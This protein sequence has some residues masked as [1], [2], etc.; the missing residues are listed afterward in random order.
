MNKYSNLFSHSQAK[1]HSAGRQK[2]LSFFLWVRDC[3]VKRFQKHGG[4]ALCTAASVVPLTAHAANF[5]VNTLSDNDADGDTL[6]EA[7]IAANGNGEA[8]TISFAPGL[9]GT[10][11]LTQGQMGITTDLVINGPEERIT[12]SGN[13]FSQIF[14]VGFSSVSLS[15]LIL[16]EGNSQEDLG[17]AIEV[18]EAQLTLTNCEISNSFCLGDGGGIGCGAGGELTLI[19]SV[20]SNNEARGSGGGISAIDFELMLTNCEVSDNTAMEEGGGVFS[21][22]FDDVVVGLTLSNCMITDN[23]A[24]GN[25]QTSGGGVHAESLGELAISN[26]VIA[27]NTAISTAGSV[28]N[29]GG[30]FCGRTLNMTV[31]N[32]EFSNNESSFFG[33]G[34]STE[35]CNDISVNNTTISENRSSIGVGMG[36]YSDRF[37]TLTNCTI[38]GNDSSGATGAGGGLYSSGADNVNVNNCSITANTAEDGGGLFI[39][40]FSQIPSSL[41]IANSICAFND[42]TSGNRDLLLSGANLSLDGPNLFSDSSS[43]GN[44]NA[45]TDLLGQ[46]IEADPANVF[47]TTSVINGITTGTLADNG[48]PV[49]TI[50]LLSGGSAHNAGL[51][52]ALSPDEQD[53]DEDGNTTEDLPIDARG[54]ARVSGSA[55]DLGAV[56]IDES[57][58]LELTLVEVDETGSA[59]LSFELSQELG[60]GE[61]WII[62]RSTDLEDFESIFVFNGTTVELEEGGNSSSLDLG[63]NAY[64]ITDTSPPQPKAF[65]RLEIAPSPAS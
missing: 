27:G 21:G 2:K 47:A 40:S 7:I 54:L 45:G 52:S 29:G 55:V 62:S 3:A 34:I 33:G 60:A 64:T 8:D 22:I 42:S 61:A 16:T 9:L 37:M 26:S 43:P 56:E 36:S 63:A 5:T 48:G 49:P 6:R 23:S 59:I 24:T 38:T 14:R 28:G 31:E 11:T 17:G 39:Y 50:L 58:P 19:N 53:L 20:L 10:L 4:L 12:I 18:F 25:G 46:I 57:S 41:E 13:D 35:Y 51:D 65:Y 30:V 32:S 44:S 15:N 1:G